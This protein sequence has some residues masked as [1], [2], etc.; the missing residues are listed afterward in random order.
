MSSAS[1][2][3]ALVATCAAK[4][5]S[6]TADHSGNVSLKWE[7]PNGETHVPANISARTHGHSQSREDITVARCLFCDV[8]SSSKRQYV[9]LGAL[10]GTRYSNTLLLETKLNWHGLLIEG[11]PGN[12]PNLIASRGHTGRNV[13]IPEAVCDPVGTATFTGPAGMGTAGIRGAMPPDYMQLWGEKRHRFRRNFTVPCRPLRDMIAMA[14]VKQ[15][16]FFS[17]DVEGAELEVLQSFDWRVPVFLWCVELRHDS[18]SK[19]VRAILTQH[20]YVETKRLPI[21]DQNSY[22]IHSSLHMSLD[23]R[24]GSC[25]CLIP[26]GVHLPSAISPTHKTANTPLGFVGALS[27]DQG[28]VHGTLAL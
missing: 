26:R 17:L 18:K 13:I 21:S 27:S 11:H 5:E 10:Q 9:E 14:G 24:L 19:L 4:I 12:A 28:G 22:F 16:H 6:S 20:G 15:V 23:Q 1:T 3:L 8:C 7:C 2:L 25:G